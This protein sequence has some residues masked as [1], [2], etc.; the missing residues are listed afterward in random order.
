MP[1]V[2]SENTHRKE[3]LAVM[4]E[5]ALFVFKDDFDFIWLNRFDDSSSEFRMLELGVQFKLALHGV[6]AAAEQ[7]RQG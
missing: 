3:L 7:G 4:N 5:L 1:Q 2:E 6:G